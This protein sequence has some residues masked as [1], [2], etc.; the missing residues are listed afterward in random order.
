MD[1]NDSALKRYILSISDA[2]PCSNG[3]KKQI[4]SQIRES[5]V[6]YLQ[7]NPEADLAAVQAHFGTPQEIAASYVH[8]AEPSALLHKMSIKK[9]VLVLVAGVMA[10]IFLM[11]IGFV[12]WAA[13]TVRPESGG[14]IEVTDQIY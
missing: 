8:E 2:L 1:R 10:A 9:K 3:V 6:D 14:S 5:I 11:W 7:E 4:M 12:A 13:A